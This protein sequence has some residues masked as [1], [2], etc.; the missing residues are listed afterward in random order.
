MKPSEQFLYLQTIVLLAFISWAKAG[1]WKPW[2]DWFLLAVIVGG[3]VGLLLIRYSEGSRFDFPWKPLLPYLVLILV[4]GGSLLNPSFK[5][6]YAEL[7]NLE[8]FEEAARRDPGLVAYVG[9]EFNDII[10]SAEQDTGRAIAL[11]LRFSRDFQERFGSY[12]SPF[13]KL[14]ENFSNEIHKA[15]IA[16]LPNAIVSE[17]SIWQ[18]FLPLALASLQGVLLWRFI[19]SRRVIRRLFFFIAA[20]G[21]LLAIAGTLQ[22]LSY[23][24]G[25]LVKEIWG[26]W[27]APE[28]RYY[29]ASFTYKNH[30]SAFALLSI[31]LATGLGLREMRNQGI[32]AW[33][34]PILPACVAIIALTSVSIPLSGSR[35]GTGFL[36]FFL[37][38]LMVYLGIH[39]AGQFQGRFKK[40]QILISTL[41]TSACVAGGLLWFGSGLHKET[42]SEAIVNTVRQWEDM[43]SGSMPMRYYLWKDTWAMFADKPLFG[44]GLGSFRALHPIYQSPEYKIQREAGTA[45][46]HRKLKPLTE[47]SHNDWFQF[48]AETGFVGVLLIISVPILGL[49]KVRH[50]LSSV[51]TWALFGCLLFTIYSFFDFPSRTPACLVG[52]VVILALGIKYA[53]LDSKRNTHRK[54]SR[55]RKAKVV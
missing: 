23:S 51:S 27:D 49:W 52:F 54:P 20:N 14:I 40:A 31:A 24:P 39:A 45:S 33:R 44:H 41:L 10:R 50:C 6:P 30:W 8:A 47:H 15:H 19:R 55:I 26:I 18:R 22:K 3:A 7:L 28:P 53:E 43:K 35:S 16:W 21:A 29:F 2:S 32:L 37:L 42:K 5:K 1:L 38:A 36:L 34:K 25:E 9:D 4:I 17:T 13:D 48:L 12:D 11:F 46:A